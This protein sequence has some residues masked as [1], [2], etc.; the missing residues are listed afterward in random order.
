MK[1]LKYLVIH[2]SDTPVN[3]DVT[4]DM[5]RSWHIIGNKWSR[6][7]YSDLIKRDGTIENLTPYDNDDIVEFSEYTFGAK[8]YNLISRHICL[9]GGRDEKGESKIFD[10]FFEIFTETQF[11]TLRNYC[12]QFNKDYPDCKIVGHNH[13]S[14]KSCPNFNVYWL[15]NFEIINID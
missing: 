2:C 6:V 8:G 9:A 14:T 13:F 11:I 10:D 7:G 15:S 12:R 4:G 3:M 1:K 5:I